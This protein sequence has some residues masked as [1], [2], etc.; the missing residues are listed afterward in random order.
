[1]S[2]KDNS[3]KMSDLQG[4]YIDCIQLYLDERHMSQIYVD[5]FQASTKTVK[6]ARLLQDD[7][8]NLLPKGGF[9]IRKWASN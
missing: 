4:Q 8:I 9:S 6:Q 3:Q 5:D 7:L 2:L 1:M